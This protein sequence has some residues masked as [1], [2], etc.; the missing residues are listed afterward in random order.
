MRNNKGESNV[1]VGLG[2]GNVIA[3][4]VSWTVNK[5]ILWAFIHGIFGWFYIIYYL[6]FVR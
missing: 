2:L 6:I 5:S 3:A 4:M 1:S